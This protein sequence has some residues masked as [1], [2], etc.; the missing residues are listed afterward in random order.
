MTAILNIFY[1]KYHHEASLMFS[2]TIHIDIL[3]CIDI[4]VC[5][6]KEMWMSCVSVFSF[7]YY[8]S[9]STSVVNVSA[10]SIETSSSQLEFM[11]F[12]RCLGR[13]FYRSFSFLTDPSLQRGAKGLLTT[14]KTTY[15]C[16][17]FMY[18]KFSGICF[19]PSY[20][21]GLNDH[22]CIL[23]CPCRM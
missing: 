15:N 8:V 7:W 13:D 4:V 12:A 17:R 10:Q 22:G 16:L 9:H 2:H 20:K 18:L 5:L 11:G 19:C 14:T 3:A 6:R 23:K 21:C 1:E